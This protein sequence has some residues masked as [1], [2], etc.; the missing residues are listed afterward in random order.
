M[1]ESFNNE[2]VVKTS[3]LKKRKISSE[4]ENIITDLFEDVDITGTNYIPCKPTLN[5]N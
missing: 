3:I 2:N 1:L 4:S 5:G